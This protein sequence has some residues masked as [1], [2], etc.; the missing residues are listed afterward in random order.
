MGRVG[1]VALPATGVGGQRFFL[2]ASAGR[3]HSAGIALHGHNIE[4]S[5]IRKVEPGEDVVPFGMENTSMNVVLQDW[6]CVRRA[7]GA[8][9]ECT[10]AG[11]G[12]K[13]PLYL[14][15]WR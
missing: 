7:A 3:V 2:C 1:P 9:Y 15:P 4:E 14:P 13:R 6:T 12:A 8:C 10:P 5:D 11:E